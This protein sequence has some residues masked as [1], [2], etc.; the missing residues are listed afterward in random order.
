MASSSH[1]PASAPSSH[2]AYGAEAKGPFG[3]RMP[4]LVEIPGGAVPSSSPCAEGG[5]ELIRAA[6]SRITQV[7]DASA[8]LAGHDGEALLIGS[9]P[10]VRET[11]ARQCHRSPL[12]SLEIVPAALGARAGVIGAAAV[13]LR[14]RLAARI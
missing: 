13:A 1:A 5:V 4:R 2:G 9:T 3:P 6:L 11:V 10:G 14:R 7:R 12:L 8:A